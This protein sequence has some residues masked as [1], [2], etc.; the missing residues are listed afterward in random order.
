[1][2][3]FALN[4]LYKYEFYGDDG[5]PLDVLP[6]WEERIIIISAE[7]FDAADAM[8]EKTAAAYEDDFRSEQGENVSVRLAYILDIF[9]VDENEGVVYSNMYEAE[10]DEVE[11]MLDI[12][13]PEEGESN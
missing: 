1:M 3:K 2:G 9:P 4:C 7:N 13:Y 6:Q 10:E 12:R 11:A 8:A 5:N